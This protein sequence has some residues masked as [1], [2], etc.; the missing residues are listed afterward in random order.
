MN[1][2]VYR[3]RRRRRRKKK[4]LIVVSSLVLLAALALAASVLL[5]YNPFLESQLRAQFGDAYFNDFGDLS[6][7][8]ASTDL[9]SI[10]DKYKPAFKTLQD[11][12]MDRLDNLLTTALEEYHQQQRD[13]TVDRFKLTNKYIQAGRILENNVDTIFYALLDEMKAELSS[14]DFTTTITVEIEETYQNAKTEKKRELLDR[15]RSDIGS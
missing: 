13:G 8:G 9:E 11:Q 5:G 15:L 12:A 4:W 2:R 1:S 6:P 7:T 10:V 14:K 3:R